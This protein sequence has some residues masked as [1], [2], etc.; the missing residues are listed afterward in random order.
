MQFLESTLEGKKGTRTLLLL[1]A[2]WRENLAE[3]EGA[4]LGHVEEAMI[5]EMMKNDI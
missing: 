5:T 4:I 2:I 3:A 1:L